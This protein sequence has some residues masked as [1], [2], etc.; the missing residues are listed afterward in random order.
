MNTSKTW[1]RTPA[2]VRNL[3]DL[4]NSSRVSSFFRRVLDG[5]KHDGFLWNFKLKLIVIKRTHPKRDQ[6][7]QPQSGISMT[8]WT[9]AE[10]QHSS[11]G[12]LMGWNMTDFY[13]T[14]NLS[15]L[16]LTLSM[17]Q[18]LYCDTVRRW[19]FCKVTIKLSSCEE[20]QKWLLGN[21]FFTVKL[22]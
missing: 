16:S 12:F 4:L 22:I 1:S 7:H 18:I 21:D 14:W 11:G 13:D 20:A 19:T 8:F 3:H 2:P 17:R 6:G 15:L 10:C 9:P 5:F